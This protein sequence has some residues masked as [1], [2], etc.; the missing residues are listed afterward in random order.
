[1]LSV[2]RRGRDL[3][4]DLPVQ[5][6]GKLLNPPE[7]LVE[8]L[9]SSPQKLLATPTKFFAVYRTEA[10]VAALSPDFG[11]L[12]TLTGKGVVVTA[13]GGRSGADFVSR[14]FA[15]AHGIPEDPAT[16]SAHCLLVPYWAEQLGL[17]RLEAAQLSQRGAKLSCELSGDRVRISGPVR[18]FLKGEISVA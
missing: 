12:G 9:R 18:P 8:G 11:L 6:P 2:D 5:M 13:P 14:F 7:A 16:G 15:P 4:L 1:L 17:T 10:E 3:W